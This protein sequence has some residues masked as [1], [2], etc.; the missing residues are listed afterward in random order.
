[1]SANGKAEDGATT[2][3]DYSVNLLDPDQ[4]STQT[5]HLENLLTEDLSSSGSFDIRGHIWKTTFGKLLQALPIPTLLIDQ[6]CRVV[7]ANQ[8]FERIPGARTQGSEFP[9]TAIFTDES[10]AKKI[11]SVVKEVFTTRKPRIAEAILGSGHEQMWNRMTFRSI[12]LATERFVLGILED[13]TAEKRILL[14]REKEDQAL[15]KAKEELER[16]VQ[17]RTVDLLKTNEA[18]RMLIESIQK[19]RTSERDVTSRNL[20]LLVSP[21]LRKLKTDPAFPDEARTI[22]NALEIALGEVLGVYCSDVAKAFPSLTPKEME[23]A[24]LL[25]CG[26]SSKQIGSIMGVGAESVQCHRHNIRKKLSITDTNEHLSS[27]LKRKLADF[28]SADRD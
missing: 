2:E 6:S 26:L 22:G 23:V 27:W 13:L 9:L 16:E 21:L 10:Q 1:M 17:D 25:V 20:R 11:L 7:R 4:L 14:L 3:I 15:R 5:I 28:S 12:R 19:M 18:L 8:A 24:E